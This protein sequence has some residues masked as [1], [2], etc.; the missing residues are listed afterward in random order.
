MGSVYLVRELHLQTSSM[1]EIAAQESFCVDLATMHHS[2]PESENISQYVSQTSNEDE[3]PMERYL[4]AMVASSWITDEK[5]DMYMS[6]YRTLDNL[7]TSQYQLLCKDQLLRA[8]NHNGN[9]NNPELS[10][11]IQEKEDN[12]LC[13]KS[14]HHIIINAWQALAVRKQLLDDPVK[15]DGRRYFMKGDAF[16]LFRREFS[17]LADLSGTLMNFLIHGKNEMEGN[18]QPLHHEEIVEDENDSNVNREELERRLINSI[19]TFVEITTSAMKLKE[20]QAQAVVDG[21]IK[22]RFENKHNVTPRQKLSTLLYSR[23]MLGYF[24][25]S[26]NTEIDIANVNENS[27]N[28]GDDTEDEDEEEE[29]ISQD[30]DL[31]PTSQISLIQRQQ[32]YLSNY[33]MDWV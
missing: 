26:L 8:R 30:E 2:I 12:D 13:L 31:V 21:L 1:Q 14:L 5:N 18:Q 10:L 25:N 29:D 22:S 6:S 15:K 28:D 33:M 7:L 20:T 24:G 19:L 16:A 4:K 27:D 32:E 11:S 17:I 23:P 9:N 3:T